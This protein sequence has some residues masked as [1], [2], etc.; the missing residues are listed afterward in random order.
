MTRVRANIGIVLSLWRIRLLRELQYR[1]NLFLH[2]FQS[3]IDLAVGL[4]TVWLVYRNVDE[5]NGWSRPELVVVLGVYLMLDGVVNGFISP[6]ISAFT[7]D[8]RDGTFD[9]VLLSPIDEQLAVSVRDFNLWAMTNLLVGTA[10]VTAAAV[11]IGSVSLGDIALFLVMLPVA[12]AIIYSF[13]IAVATSAFWLV[14]IDEVMFRMFQSASYAGRWPLGV[15]PGWLKGVLTAVVPI[16]L[17]VT[18]PASALV[19]RLEPRYVAGSIAIAA[20][21]VFGSRAMFRRG[22]RSYSGASA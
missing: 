3:F 15:Y 20:V 9:F 12:A 16:G 14:S 4:F 8:I 7:A 6:M 11:Q 5:L 17:A 1:S 10:L 13:F 21:A 18:I 22:I 19:D 2:L